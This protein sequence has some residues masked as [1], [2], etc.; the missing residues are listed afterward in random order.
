MQ[1]KFGDAYLCVDAGQ[2]RTAFL[3]H[4]EKGSVLALSLS[5]D[6]HLLDG[7]SHERVDT[8]TEANRSADVGRGSTQDVT[9]DRTPCDTQAA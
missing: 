4:D 6:H 9:R 8:C 5:T 2:L 3:S 7:T 1:S